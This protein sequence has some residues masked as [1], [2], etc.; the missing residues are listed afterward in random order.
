MAESYLI[1]NAIY[2][3]A[4]KGLE[5]QKEACAEKKT[6][7]AD[8]AAQLDELLPDM[9]TLEEYWNHAKTAFNTLERNPE[10]AQGKLKDFYYDKKHDCLWQ[11]KARGRKTRYNR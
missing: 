4:V 2:D 6:Y 11:S 1:T 5:R 10:S 8:R 3:G 9:E 7:Y